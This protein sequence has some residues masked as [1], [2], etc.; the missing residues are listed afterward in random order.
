MPIGA[1]IISIETKDGRPTL[2]VEAE[3]DSLIEERSFADYDP[4]ETL[5]ENP[6][7]Y[8]GTYHAKNGSLVGDVYEIT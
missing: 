1:I 6:G 7:D 8:I 4:G 2:L 3:V 5:P